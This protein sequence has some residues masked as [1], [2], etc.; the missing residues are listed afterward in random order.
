MKTYSQACHLAWNDYRWLQFWIQVAGRHPF[1]TSKSP[2][3][4]VVSTCWKTSQRNDSQLGKSS[5]IIPPKWTGWWFFATPLKNHG[6]KVSQLGWWHSQYDGTVIKFHGSIIDY[7]IP[8]YPIKNIIISQS[9]ESHKRHVPK[10]QPGDHS[11][12]H[13]QAVDQELRLWEIKAHTLHHLPRKKSHLIATTGIYPRLITV[14]WKNIN[15]NRHG[16]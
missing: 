2:W 9:M 13:Q 16:Y 14:S 12:S 5:K 7:Y 15:S 1:F 10:N 4:S 6:V 3:C 8:L 11:K